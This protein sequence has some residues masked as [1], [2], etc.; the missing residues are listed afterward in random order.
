[1]SQNKQETSQSAATERKEA[2]FSLDWVR[3]GIAVAGMVLII[4]FSHYYC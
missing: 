4:I 3:L 2:G 1:M